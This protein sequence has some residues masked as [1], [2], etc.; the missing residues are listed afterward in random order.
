MNK[1]VAIVFMALTLVFST[2]FAVGCSNKIE[3]I[4]KESKS[5]MDDAN[6]ENKKEKIKIAALKGPTGMG[7]VKLMEENK[8]DYDITMFNSPTQIVPKIVNGEFDVAAVPANSA[9]VLYNKTKGGV[10]L[11][12]INTL[13]VLHIVENGDTIKSIKDLKGK[14][15]YAS[16][17]GAVPEYVLNYILK[18]NGLEPDKDVKIEYKMHHSD[19]ATAVASKKVEIA[20]LPEPFVTTVKMKNKDLKIQLDLT[21]EW[22]KVSDANSKLVM[23]TLICRKDFIDKRGKD[24]D[25][26][27]DRY[28]KSIDFVNS[29]KT[30]AGKLIEKNGIILKA[31]IAEKAIPKCNIVFISSQDGKDSLEKFYSILNKSNPKSIGGK[32]PDENFYYTSKKTN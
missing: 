8:D 14:T 11:V 19:L 1:R 26:F 15:L 17:K 13:G 29:N 31:A 21:K 28:R 9:A 22:E 24:V 4:N 23:G 12:G 20:V 7:L 6:K 27:L 18:K 3:N 16:G 10:K 5:S 25:E 32:I 2:L 30:E